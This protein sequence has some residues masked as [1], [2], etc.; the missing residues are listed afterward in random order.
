MRDL[1]LVV[2]VA[3]AACGGGKEAPPSSGRGSESGSQVTPVQP[4]VTG[5]KIF[6]DDVEVATLDVAKVGAWPRLDTLVP[7]NARRLGTWQAITIKSGKPAPSELANP[8]Q[9]Y[10]DYAPALFPGEGG[11]ISF[12][13]FDP[14]ELGKRGKPALREDGVTELRIKLDTSGAR[15]G[16]DHGGGEVIDPANVSLAI[17][18]PKGGTKLSGEKLLSLPREPMPGGGGEAQGWQIPQ[19]LEA[20][21]VKKF[22][23]LRLVDAGGMTLPLEK[24]EIDANTVPFLKLNRQGALRYR[25]YKKAGS[26]WQAAADLRNVATIEVLE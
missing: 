1:S 12:G 19:L 15:G 5:L 14:V 17:K 9:T 23:K 11:G 22:K 10:R 13:M 18:T 4:R 16:N 24:A 8:F 26:G 21:G 3:L 7:E 6:V 20:A 2:L 25:L